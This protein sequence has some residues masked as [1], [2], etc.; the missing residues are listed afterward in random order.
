MDEAIINKFKAEI[1][2]RSKIYDETLKTQVGSQ[3]AFWKGKKAAMADMFYLIERI[4][5]EEQ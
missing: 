4:S 1:T 5:E 2:R 3:V